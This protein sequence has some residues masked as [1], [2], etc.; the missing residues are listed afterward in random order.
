MGWQ[1]EAYLQQMVVPGAL[2]NGRASRQLPG[3]AGLQMFP[4]Y[5]HCPG[6]RAR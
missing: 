6:T 1:S 5:S 3:Y 4:L 2:S